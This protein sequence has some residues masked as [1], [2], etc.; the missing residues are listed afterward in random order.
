MSENIVLH[1]GGAGTRI[2]TEFW[3]TMREEHGLKGGKVEGRTQVYF[4]ENSKGQFEN[5]NIY[6]DTD[7]TIYSTLRK[8]GLFVPNESVVVGHS[9]CHNLYAERYGG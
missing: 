4:H 9:S 8:E 3:K 1:I 5:R 6:I 2:G 7:P